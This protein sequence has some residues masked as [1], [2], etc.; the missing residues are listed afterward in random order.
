MED[1]GK[2]RQSKGQAIMISVPYQGHINPFVSLALNLASKGFSVTFVHLE[3][4]HHKLS[5]AY[6]NTDD[7]DIFSDARRSGLDINYTTISDGFPLE[8]DRVA[9]F[10]DYWTSMVRDLGD[11]VA[12]FVGKLIGSDPNQAH[13]LIAD[14]VYNWPADVADKYGLVNVSFWTQPALVFSLAYHWDLL[15]QKGHVPCTGNIA[16]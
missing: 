12:E 2:K 6:A 9:Y 13:F 1:A 10:E 4:V 11:R 16:S 8:F 5:Q 3:F 15:Q 7:V 14:T